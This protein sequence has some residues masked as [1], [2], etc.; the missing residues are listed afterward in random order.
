MAGSVSIMLIPNGS[1]EF[2]FTITSTNYTSFF[3]KTIHSHDSHCVY[4]FM[5]IR[6]KQDSLAIL[7]S[8]ITM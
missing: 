6:Q 5:E 4:I 3:A 7:N 8:Q 1:I 2:V